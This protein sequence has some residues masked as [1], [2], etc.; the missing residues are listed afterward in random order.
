MSEFL[1]R[2]SLL[3]P[4]LLIATVAAAQR[5]AAAQPATSLQAFPT[6]EAAATALTEAIRSMDEKVLAAMLGKDWSVFAP[7]RDQDFGMDREAYLAA[8]QAGNKTVVDGDK[9]TIEVGKDG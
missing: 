3:A 6:P 8:W 1:Q 7:A 5:Q 4:A 9:A 2:R